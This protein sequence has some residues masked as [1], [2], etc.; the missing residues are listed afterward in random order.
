MKLQWLEDFGKGLEEV[1]NEQ[2]E[3]LRQTTDIVAN[4]RCGHSRTL[5]QCLQQVCYVTEKLI[6]IIP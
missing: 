4:N 5:P 6:I 1:E 2:K 3:S